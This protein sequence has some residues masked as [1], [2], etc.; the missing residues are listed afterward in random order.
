MTDARGQGLE[1]VIERIGVL[2]REFAARGT[3]P[4][5]DRRLGRAPMNL[6]FA[7][8]RSDGLSVAQL[9]DRLS[10]TSGAVSQTIDTLRSAGLVTSDVNP[11][12]RR[13]RIIRL[14]PDAR[15]EVHDFERGYFDAI[16][17]RFDGLTTEQVLE[18]DRIL[19]SIGETTGAET[20]GANANSADTNSA[21]V[22]RTE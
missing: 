12:D 16:A 19:A 8:S 21:D 1:R 4:F 22:K 6:L 18:L 5:K 7:L 11:T 14:T 15:T 17:P 3:Y 9:A 20:T 13:G 10:V 2:T